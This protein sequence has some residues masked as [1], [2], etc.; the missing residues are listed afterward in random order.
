M[1]YIGFNTPEALQTDTMLA[2]LLSFINTQ[3]LENSK[4]PTRNQ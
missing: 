2:Q 4:V 3:E 1:V